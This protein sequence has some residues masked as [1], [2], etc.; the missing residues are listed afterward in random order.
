[1]ACD[2]VHLVIGE[3]LGERFWPALD[4]VV[5]AEDVLTALDSGD[6]SETLSGGVVLAVDYAKPV[7][8]NDRGEQDNGCDGLR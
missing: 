6:G 3:T 1:V 2:Q 8:C 7:A 5:G 4:R